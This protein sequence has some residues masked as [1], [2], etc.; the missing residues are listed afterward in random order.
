MTKFYRWFDRLQEPGRFL[1]FMVFIL[2]CVSA[3]NSEAFISSPR[4]VTFAALAGWGA[5]L[6]LIV[7]RAHYLYF[8]KRERRE[9][10]RL[11]VIAGGKRG[12]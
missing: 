7:T 6:F 8:R 9:Q 12:K 4:V 2:V 3:A 10:P 5:M 1:I 11:R